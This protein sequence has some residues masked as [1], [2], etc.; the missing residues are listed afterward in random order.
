MA[1]YGLPIWSLGRHGKAGLYS[2]GALV[3]WAVESNDLDAEEDDDLTHAAV[4]ERVGDPR[5]LPDV[6]ML[7]A[8]D[9]TVSSIAGR[10]SEE[11]AR[12]L[13]QIHPDLRLQD[14]DAPR[15]DF[16]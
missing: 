5:W 12:R 1:D 14:P 9:G 4:G 7:I 15:W 2:N 10:P 3:V 11:L 13:Q 6:A 8:P 16:G